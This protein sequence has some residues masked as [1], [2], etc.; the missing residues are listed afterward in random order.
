MS[1]IPKPS[2]IARPLTTSQTKE[3]GGGSDVSISEVSSNP[4]NLKVGDKV[5][6]RG[7]TPGVISFLGETKFASGLWAGVVLDKPEGKNDGSVNGVSYFKCK[8]MYGVFSRPSRLSLRDAL[9]NT[10]KGPIPNINFPQLNLPYSKEKVSVQSLNSQLCLGTSPT[11]TLQQSIISSF[12][13]PTQR[14]PS[15]TGSQISISTLKSSE[16]PQ[17]GDRVI[18][19]ST[20]SNSKVG[21]L[22]YLGK[23]EFAQGEWAGVEL[24]LPYGKNDG[25]VQ[26]VAYFECKPNHGVFVLS[27]KVTKSP[28]SFMQFRQISNLSSASIATPNRRI[29][30][31][32]SD[33]SNI[34][35]TSTSAGKRRS[36]SSINAPEMLKLSLKEKE[37]EIEKITKEMELE[38]AQFSKAAN[39]TDILESKLKEMEREFGTFKLES[40]SSEHKKD[41]RIS[42]L[43]SKLSEEK[44]KFEDLQFQF[45]ELH[46]SKGS[47]EDQEEKE[48]SLLK[49]ELVESESTIEKL[50]EVEIYFKKVQ[51]ESKTMIKD[52]EEKCSVLAFE[53]EEKTVAL[54]LEV[55]ELKKN[56]ESYKI[57]LERERERSISVQGKMKTEEE[58]V[59][60][61]IETLEE[62]ISK[63]EDE[64]LEMNMKIESFEKSEQCTFEKYEKALSELKESDLKN[65]ELTTKTSQMEV[66]LKCQY[67][68]VDRLTNK[69]NGLNE[70]M[71]LKDTEIKS[72]KK[73]LTQTQKSLKSTKE[74]SEKAMARLSESDSST[75]IEISK[76]MGE[77]AALREKLD[78]DSENM[79]SS[80]KLVESIKEKLERTELEFIEA[81]K[82]FENVCSI[83]RNLEKEIETLRSGSS[84]NNE[85]VKRLSG[86]I[87]LKDSELSSLRGDV[88]ILKSQ[89][90]T[91]KDVIT[92]TEFEAK[93]K[94][95]LLIKEQEKDIFK[96]MEA[97]KKS[98]GLLKKMEK[99]KADAIDACN[100]K[101]NAARKELNEQINE[102]KVE[103][104]ETKVENTRLTED[105]ERSRVHATQTGS[106]TSEELSSL[107]E[108]IES[109]IKMTKFKEQELEDLQNELVESKAKLQSVS[110]E[111]S[112]ESKFRVELQEKL[113]S[114]HSTHDEEMGELVD[115]VN[116]LKEKDDELKVAMSQL[117]IKADTLV[118]VERDAERKEKLY[119]EELDRIKVECQDKIQVLTQSLEDT[120]AQISYL[121]ESSASSKVEYDLR[122]EKLK[123]EK[124]Q[125]EDEH[126]KEMDKKDELIQRLK[127]E[128][129]SNEVEQEVIN[130][131]LKAKIEELEQVSMDLEVKEASFSNKVRINDESHNSEVEILVSKVED[132]KIEII[133]LNEKLARTKADHDSKIDELKLEKKVEVNNL[134]DLLSERDRD[135]VDHKAKISELEN[136]ITD[137]IRTSEDE[138]NLLNAKVVKF[139]SEFEELR[140]I[141]RELDSR[142]KTI[143]TQRDEMSMQNEELNVKIVEKERQ[144]N[145]CTSQFQTIKVSFER[146]KKELAE[147]IE[148]SIEISSGND[149]LVTAINMERKRVD[150]LQVALGETESERDTLSQQLEDFE[151]TKERLRI[152]EGSEHELNGM[153]EELKR[154]SASM[155]DKFSAERKE[156]NEVVENSHILLTEKIEEFKSLKKESELLHSENAQINSFKRNILILEQEKRE[157]E[158]KLNLL[159]T[160]NVMGKPD[161]MK[162]STTTVN[163]ID[164]EDE[165]ESNENLRSQI[166]FLNSVIVDMQRKNDKYKMKL[167]LYESGKVLGGDMDDENSQLNLLLNG[168]NANQVPPRLFCDICDQFDLHDTEDCPTQAMMVVDEG[169]HTRNTA[170]R[171][172]NR[173]YCESCEVFGHATQDCNDEE[174]F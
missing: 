18:V 76:L 134:Q 157:M 87:S 128:L 43:S 40:I 44:Q 73:I 166:N 112:K 131:E 105:L 5:C 47:A 148:K 62:Y 174:T 35:A 104:M 96:L 10:R 171:S 169:S 50:K 78:E 77:N 31:Q 101:M 25:T 64:I 88:N 164:N 141:R 97:L 79:N 89:L 21:T 145:E 144:V 56:V 38:R 100:S 114:L 135:I 67:G 153:I 17:L 71:E 110:K 84:I 83:N 160:N 92:Q 113:E 90:N 16:S 143:E 137:I 127:S 161:I 28:R 7:N 172:S 155:Q 123:T 95:A 80:N 136:Q 12:D 133:D 150:E 149:E 82:K 102:L 125:L 15:P 51:S 116:D 14:T 3:K 147:H 106:E 122:K 93:E 152:V 91:L 129:S 68:E 61:K 118:K 75:N 59:T 1:S 54:N 30:R 11:K 37:A 85:E 33:L 103:M 29:C 170:S 57:S 13:D 6:V 36:V 94:E 120:N 4:L 121:K 42:E 159:G 81:N 124:Q 60:R 26:G 117:E 22:R 108:A 115:V 49:K 156:M 34:S 19:S 53:A 111:L 65:Q 154:Q 130:E 167:E 107:K 146:T 2:R 72:V 173:P 132:A 165:E 109:N 162:K 138:V 48:I 46:L 52:L 24:D 158:N 41:E 27:S 139:S 74:E 119:K 58:S 39:Q 32:R 45:E 55:D 168:I 9:E 63:K 98:E 23:A 151:A 8:P 140:T 66:E 69:I 86:C 126:N 99:T 70:V 142:V 163:I 20:T